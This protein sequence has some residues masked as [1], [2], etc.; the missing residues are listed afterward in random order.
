MLR[1]LFCLTLAC[2]LVLTSVSCKKEKRPEGMPEI[3]PVTLKIIQG[4]QPLEG[5][6]VSMT[7]DDPILVKFPAGGVSDKDGL[8]QVLTYGFKGAPA[9]KFKVTVA[10]YEVLN[11]PSSYE[12]AQKMQSEGLQEES[13]DLVEP[14]YGAKATTSLTVEVQASKS[15]QTFDLDVGEPVRISRAD[16]MH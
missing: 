6:E 11:R 10:K 3:Y 4:G 2:A 7:S 16:M 15:A 13:F 8:A 12:E 14:E 5:A 9:G 1:K